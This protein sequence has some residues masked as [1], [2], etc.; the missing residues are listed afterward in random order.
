[1][2]A[3]SRSRTTSSTTVAFRAFVLDD[4]FDFYEVKASTRVARKLITGI[5]DKTIGLDKNPYIGQK[6]NFYMTALKISDI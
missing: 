3:R 4:I 1:M 5:I 6:K 2:I